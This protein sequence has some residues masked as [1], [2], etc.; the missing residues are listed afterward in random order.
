MSGKYTLTRLQ[1]NGQQHGQD[2][3]G[4]NKQR[5]QESHSRRRSTTNLLPSLR[6]LLRPN[7]GIGLDAYM[8][9]NKQMKLF[10]SLESYFSGA[11]VVRFGVEP[12]RFPFLR[13]QCSPELRLSVRLP[14]LHVSEFNQL[15]MGSQLTLFQNGQSPKIDTT[16]F[17][18]FWQGIK[19]FVQPIGGV[20]RRASLGELLLNKNQRR[21]LRD[22][23]D[24][25][26][27]RRDMK[28]SDRQRKHEQFLKD[29]DGENKLE[30]A[31]D[32]DVVRDLAEKLKHRYHQRMQ[33]N[34]EMDPP[35]LSESEFGQVGGTEGGSG[36]NVKDN[37]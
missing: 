10:M 31:N 24:Q 4:A 30:S 22:V 7:P 19:K 16:G 3:A 25:T 35:S 6:I 20:Q 12:L 9:F 18:E 36:N 13:L 33:L 8:P 29:F 11:S 23:L 28:K 37:G 32:G 34:R 2:P 27:L 21:V 5:N 15:Y 26:R 17:G 14:L 1:N